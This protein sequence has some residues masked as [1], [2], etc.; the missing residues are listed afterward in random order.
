MLHTY[1]G[2]QANEALSRLLAY[3]LGS[4]FGGSINIRAS[5]YSMF[6]ET[7]KGSEIVSM[8]TGPEP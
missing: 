7:E 5:P 6:I 3:M 2:T 4:R 8:I 1:L